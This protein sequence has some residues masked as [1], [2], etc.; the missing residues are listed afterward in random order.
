MG[1]F[2]Q[3][4]PRQGVLPEVHQVDQQGEG[5]VQAGG[6]EG[7]LEALGPAQEQAG[8]ELRD[9]GEGAEV[10]LPARDLGEGR[11]PEARLPVRRRAE[12]YHR[13]RLL[14]CVTCYHHRFGVRG[15][16]TCC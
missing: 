10:L 1:I 6:L 11:W 4:P 3:A 14:R 9:D 12:R 5:G 7:G 8:H 16:H 13:D 2:A 15:P